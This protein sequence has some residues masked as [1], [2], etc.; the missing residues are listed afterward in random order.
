M[1]WGVSGIEGDTEL[2][3]LQDTVKNKIGQF[4]NFD[5]LNETIPIDEGE[6]IMK[7]KCTTNSHL[8]NSYEMTV[9]S[10]LQ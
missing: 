2:N 1:N 9:V 4:A 6:K 10:P 3:S 5:Q 8:N 7:E